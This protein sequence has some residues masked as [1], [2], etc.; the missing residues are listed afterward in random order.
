MN[1]THA[2]HFLRRNASSKYYQTEFL[3]LSHQFIRPQ[4]ALNATFS[5]VIFTSQCNFSLLDNHCD[6]ITWNEL[7][8]LSIVLPNR[9]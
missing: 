5:L 7:N 4:W 9:P 1:N 3:T 6:V 8:R 2:I